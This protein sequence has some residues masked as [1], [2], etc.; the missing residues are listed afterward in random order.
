MNR[1]LSLILSILLFLGIFTG[2]PA[3]VGTRWELKGWSVSSCDPSAYTV[4]LEFDK[5]SFS[6]QAPVNS[7]GGNYAAFKSGRLVIGSI[8]ATEMAGP[9]EAMRVEA[10]YFELLGMVKQYSVNG[11]TL[12]L[13]D[14]NGNELL[15]FERA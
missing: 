12:T 9:P 15:I 2:I 1:I 13:Q 7:Y 10:V 3:T 14:G 5:S 8:W 4:T 6:G 11:D